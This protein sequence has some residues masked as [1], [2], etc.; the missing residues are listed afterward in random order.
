MGAFRVL[1][2]LLMLHVGVLLSCSNNDGIQLPEQEAL[3]SGP[4]Y[5]VA[6]E[7]Y[8]RIHGEPSREAT[9]VAHLRRGDVATI[10]AHSAFVD[11]INEVL[12]R[13][14]EVE[15]TG[16]S[17][18]VFGGHLSLFNRRTQAENSAASLE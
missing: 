8:V 3:T 15:A 2:P 7:Q 6:V 10:T 5:A 17:G 13:W 4:R 18:W 12:S 9:V 1:L 16:G 14:Y 11:N